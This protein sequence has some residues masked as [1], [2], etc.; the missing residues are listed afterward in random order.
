MNSPESSSSYEAIGDASDAEIVLFWI[1]EIE[2]PCDVDNTDVD[3]AGTYVDHVIKN[4]IPKIKNEELR[5]QLEI[6]VER[7]LSENKS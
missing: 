7:W 6:V 2:H 3:L 1:N 4:V 5:R